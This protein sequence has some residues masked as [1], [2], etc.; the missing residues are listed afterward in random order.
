MAK[1]DWQM[2][3]TVLPDD[4]NQIGQE[5]NQNRDNLAAHANLTTGVHGAT[6]TAAP[7]TIVQ[8]D[9]QGRIKA[10][11]PAE[12]DDV[13][14]KAE[15]DTLQSSVNNVSSSLDAHAS[16][17]SN[18]H[19]VT[20]DQVGLGNV[21]NYGIATQAQAEAGTANNVYMTPQR[22]KQ[23]ID[24]LSPVKSVN[25]KTGVVTLAASDVGAAP[26]SHVGAGGTAHAVATTS[27][28]GFM[29]AADKTKLNGIEA[30]AQV[31]LVKHYEEGVWTPELKFGGASAGSAGFFNA[32]RYTRIG[33]M[34]F[35]DC[36]IQL[37][38]KGSSTGKAAIGGLPFRPRSIL[39]SIGA[40]GSRNVTLPS[41]KTSLISKVD[42]FSLDIEVFA[43]GSGGDYVY[44]S[45]SNFSNGSE[46]VISIAYLI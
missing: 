15:I 28:A 34:V 4:L 46:L 5:I 35:I 9:A 10:A 16:N 7:N 21:Q 42:E 3:D 32:G 18:P 20:K 27:V 38:A 36:L 19:G 13:A 6:S 45:D 33:N 14:R 39:P 12:A 40:T 31:N 26:F 29:S 8:R 17:T 23:A 11:A 24:A 22:T 1:T 25:G 41:S 44:L 30:G 2:G 37:S 43:Y